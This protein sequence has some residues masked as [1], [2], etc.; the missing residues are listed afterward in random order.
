MSIVVERLSHDELREAIE[1]FGFGSE[2]HCGVPGESP[3]LVTPP[4]RW[5]RYTQTSVA[6]GHEIAV[7]PVQLVRAFSAFARDGTLPPSRITAADPSGIPFA[8]RRRACS[9]AV[10]D[11][12]RRT[13]RQVMTE[14]TGRPAQSQHYRLFGKSGTAQLP[15]PATGGYYEGRY[16]SNFIAGAPFEEPRIVVLCVIDDPDKSRGHFGGRV[17]GP[18]VRDVIDESLEYLGV[19]PDKD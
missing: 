8:F 13:L 17:A 18:I 4:D 11:L 19:P 3:G 7:T 5:S 10:A 2:T 12:V 15:D 1:R 9:E 16:V 6:I 14:G